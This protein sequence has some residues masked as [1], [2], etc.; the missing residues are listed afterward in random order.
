[1]RRTIRR[2]ETYILSFDDECDV[3]ICD[4]SVESGEYG[5]EEEIEK[6]EELDVRGKMFSGIGWGVKLGFK[7]C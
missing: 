1:M 2:L 5:V 4:R 3:I 7:I 6:Q